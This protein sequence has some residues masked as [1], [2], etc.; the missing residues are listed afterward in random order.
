MP[1]SLGSLDPN[2]VTDFSY[3]W[4][5]QLAEGEALASIADVSF[6]EA[7]GTNQPNAASVASNLTRVWLTGGTA[8][9]RA[10]F[11]V[12]VTTDSSP[13]RTLE[14]AFSVD[15][16]ETTYEAPVETEVQRLT[17]E[18]AEAKAQRALVAQGKGVIDAWRD[19]R[20]IRRMMPTLAD[21]ERHI[22][23]LES[24]LYAAQVAAGETPTS[25]RRASAIELGWSN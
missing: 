21:L 20:R 7:A 4:S 19:G 9:S 14:E 6:V 12:R 22:R 1:I 18:I 10:I 2:E 16:V 24:E 11:T 13:P 15:I 17:R 5:G 8:G 3:N 25:R 23:Q